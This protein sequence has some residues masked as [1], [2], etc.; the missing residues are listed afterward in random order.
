MY[1]CIYMYI[2]IYISFFFQVSGGNL[3]ELYTCCARDGLGS[4][5]CAGVPEGPL[6][7]ILYQS[8]EALKY[9]HARYF[10]VFF[11]FPHAILLSECRGAR[12]YARKVHV[13]KS[14]L[15]ATFQ[16][17]CT[18]VVTSGYMHLRHLILWD[19]KPVNVLGYEARKCTR[20]R[21]PLMY[22]STKPVNVLGYEARK[23]TR[24]QSP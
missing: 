16:S 7:A 11:F 22:Q 23:C 21:S 1:I 14:P 10:F 9:M 13:L 18:R 4:N 3:G 12:V 8:V 6:H 17:K 24:V 15:L 20:V 2:Y 19:M 5:S